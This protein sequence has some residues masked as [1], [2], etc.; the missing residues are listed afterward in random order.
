MPGIGSRPRRS[1]DRAENVQRQF[2]VLFVEFFKAR[3]ALGN[4]IFFE[5][6]F[7]RADQTAVNHRVRRDHRRAE[8]FLLIGFILEPFPESI[9]IAEIVS[10]AEQFI[11]RNDHFIAELFRDFNRLLFGNRTVVNRD[12]KNFSRHAVVFFFRF[13]RL[14]A[15][16][17]QTNDRAE[18]FQQFINLD[19]SPLTYD[20]KSRCR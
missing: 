18:H 3:G 4:D 13:R 6:V 7:A 10:I 8:Q 9:G 20:N 19:H 15:N 2:F 1:H 12:V 11:G 17:N 14:N 16:C 5:T